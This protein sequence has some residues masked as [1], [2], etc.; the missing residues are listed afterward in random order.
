MAYI[1]SEIE[2]IWCGGRMRR[3]TA[4]SSPSINHVTYFCVSCGAVVH[5]A[6]NHKK[7]IS[8][9]EVEYKTDGDGDANEE[10]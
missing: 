9:I 3:G 7:K 4:F 1:P 2:C 5:F 8:G 6:V 10:T